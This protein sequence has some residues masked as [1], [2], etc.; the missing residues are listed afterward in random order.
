[1]GSSPW[2]HKESDVTNTFTLFSSWLGLTVK[3]L[4]WCLLGAVLWCA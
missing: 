4:A 1:M 2:G 3:H